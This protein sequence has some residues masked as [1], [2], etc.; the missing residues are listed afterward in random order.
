MNLLKIIILFSVIVILS[1]FI[2]Y[3]D[4][5]EDKL[6]GTW[7]YSNQHNQSIQFKKERSFDSKKPGI[8]FKKNGT[9]VKRQN[10]GWCG[11]PPI[12]YQNYKGTWKTTSDSTLNIRY[13]YW[14]GK[15]EEDWLI[16]DLSKNIIAVKSL[17]HRIE[18]NK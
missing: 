18:K 10:S 17:N 16:T 11:T 7:V 4:T 12:S 13:E 2:S 5:L 14:G 15:I 3:S 1:S 6:L 8:E 9:L